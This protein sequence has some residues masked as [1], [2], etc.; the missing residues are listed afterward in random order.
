LYPVL[1]VVVIRTGIRYGL[2][3]MYL[4]W[5]AA[6]AAMPLLLRRT[7]WR[8]ET[9]IAVALLLMLACT[10]MFFSSLVR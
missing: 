9:E 10:P 1:L 3:T 5:G 2:R 6:L 7:F 8:T 4:S